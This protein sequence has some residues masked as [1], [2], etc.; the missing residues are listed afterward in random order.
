MCS[1]KGAQFSTVD[2]DG[3]TALHVASCEGHVH[4]VRYL[5]D[6]GAPVHVRDRFG[7]SPLDN[8]LS[9]KHAG[10]VELLM[11]TG[12]HLTLTPMAQAAEL[13]R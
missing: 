7:S 10:V 13:C 1:L 12:A 9:F 8:A 3:R 11:T 2:Y 6:L 5:L 4:I